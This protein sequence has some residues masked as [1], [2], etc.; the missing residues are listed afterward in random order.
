MLVPFLFEICHPFQDRFHRGTAKAETARL[1]IGRDGSKSWY[2]PTIYQR[3][4]TLPYF[5]M[6]SPLSPN[7]RPS[8]DIH[9]ANGGMV[10][11]TGRLGCVIPANPIHYSG[12]QRVKIEQ[13]SRSRNSNQES[14]HRRHLRGLL[15]ECVLARVRDVEESV[16]ILVFLVDAAHQS[17]SRR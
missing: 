16:F 10:G 17:G 15:A 14:E 8:R 3:K 11:F 1:E 7:H 4:R 6:S 9:P 2:C 13:A 5:I 12:L